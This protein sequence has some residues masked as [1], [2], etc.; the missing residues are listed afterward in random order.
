MNA[1]PNAERISQVINEW[2]NASAMLFMIGSFIQ[3]DLFTHSP[4]GDSEQ[5]QV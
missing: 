2:I 5:R 1:L 3:F 4:S